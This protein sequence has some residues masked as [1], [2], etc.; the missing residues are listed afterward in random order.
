ME[1]ENIRKQLYSL[2]E[3]L[4]SFYNRLPCDYDCPIDLPS[5]YAFSG[6]KQYKASMD[7]RWEVKLV[8]GRRCICIPVEYC[9]REKIRDGKYNFYGNQKPI[10]EE[11][12]PQEVLDGEWH[13]YRF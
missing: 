10:R 1:T 2:N 3:Q 11:D 4:K 6:D 9:V 8:D 5:V 7:Y 12:I 13:D